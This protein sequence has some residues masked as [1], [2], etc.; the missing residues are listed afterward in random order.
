MAQAPKPLDP[1]LSVQHRFGAEL[2]AFRI[3]KAMSQADLAKLIHV[4]PDLVAK[5]EKA[6]RGFLKTDP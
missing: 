3:R 6:C 2:R 5:V 4:S 1:S